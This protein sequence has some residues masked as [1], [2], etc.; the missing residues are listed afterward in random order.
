MN[1]INI[2][3]MNQ[4]H[5]YNNGAFSKKVLFH[6]GWIPYEFMKVLHRHLKLV[7]SMEF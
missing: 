2:Y 5:H 7:V 6:C 3:V 4:C 1:K